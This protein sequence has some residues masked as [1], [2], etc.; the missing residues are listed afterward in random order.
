[1]IS[2][3]PEMKRSHR[4]DVVFQ[5]SELKKYLGKTFGPVAGNQKVF[6]L[7]RISIFFK[8]FLLFL[9]NVLHH[10]KWGRVPPDRPDD[11]K[12]PRNEEISSS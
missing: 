6:L 9:S 2:K 1:M 7:L 8:D 11:L 10:F 3:T 4:A 5:K 12:N